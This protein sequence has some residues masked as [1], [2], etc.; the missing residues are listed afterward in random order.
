MKV[1]TAE[2][3]QTL[4]RRAAQLGLSPDIL[5]QN[6]GLAAAREMWKLRHG[7][8]GKSVLILVGPGNNGGD[9][10][11]VARHLHQ[12]GA[13]VH[14]YLCSARP[15]GDANL[16][17]AREQDIPIVEAAHD[18]SLASLGSMLVSTDVVVDALFGTGQSRPLEGTFK[19]ALRWVAQ[20]KAGR[21]ELFLVALDLPSGLHADTG[22][23]DPAC[24]TVDA[25][26]TLGYPK[27]G[28]FTAGG[29]ERAGRI[30]VADIGI[31]GHLA[32]DMPTDLITGEWASSVIPSRPPDAHKGTFGRAL[33]VAGS[34]NYIGAAHLACL[35]A[36]RVGAG[37]VTL[38]TPRSLHP[39]LAA[40]LIET[41]YLPLPEAEPGVVAAEA[42]PV[43]N[44]ALADYNALLLGCGLGQRPSVREFIRQVLLE[45]HAN[46][47]QSLVV[48]ADG[49]NNLA[50]IPEWWKALDRDAI[51]TPHPGEMSRLTGLAISQIQEERLA[52]AKRAAAQWGKVVVL[53]GAYT[54]VADP[55]GWAKI[56]A[57][58]NPGL[59]S[60]GTGDVLAGAILGLL[61]QGLHPF[62]AAACGV[63][64]HSA[65][66]EMVRQAMGDTGMIASDLLPCLPQVLKSL[67]D[68]K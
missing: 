39:I 10:L 29:A 50:Q 14:I 62:E 18:V 66:G 3:M 33:V 21:P 56:D 52:Q 16:R 6:A 1:V 54:V 28:L 13:R 34:I 42:A 27:L 24:L 68:R 37:L 49:L 25:T 17:L 30:V 64:L 4:E 60:G 63:Y 51:L 36:L 32:D 22:A 5:M 35:G 40:K 12:W 19:E 26:I 2:Q 44:D 55:Q 20:A 38:A 53:K 46:L 67:K 11:V 31:P 61:A 47:P 23:V 57:S 41:T 65:A 48:D 58:A 45:P 9:G 8:A 59:A 43:V 7:L 15:L